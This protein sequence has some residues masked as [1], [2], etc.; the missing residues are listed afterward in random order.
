MKNFIYIYLSIYTIYLYLYKQGYSSGRGLIC[1]DGLG[2][3][4]NRRI[5]PHRLFTPDPL[6]FTGHL[7]GRDARR[8]DRL[9]LRPRR[10]RQ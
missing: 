8:G 1:S 10:F 2:L 7:P 9:F 5:H 4:V 6:S 3:I